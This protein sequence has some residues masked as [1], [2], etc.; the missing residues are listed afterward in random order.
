LLVN[1]WSGFQVSL[2]KFFSDDC[3]LVDEDKGAKFYTFFCV[4][5]WIRSRFSYMV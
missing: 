3:F 4:K 2:S 5:C 1:I